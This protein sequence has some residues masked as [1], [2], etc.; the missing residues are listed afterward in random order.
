MRNQVNERTIERTN[1]RMDLLVYQQVCMY[2]WHCC[3]QGKPGS[4]NL[5][6][7]DSRWIIAGS[8]VVALTGY[9]SEEAAKQY[10]AMDDSM[11]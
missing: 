7:A 6:M 3:G 11:R 8:A 4:V 5:S 2:E 9:Q 10:P 1:E